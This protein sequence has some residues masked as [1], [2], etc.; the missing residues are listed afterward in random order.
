MHC[1]FFS[2]YR[3][4]VFFHI[5]IIAAY[6]GQDP[7]VYIYFV[8]LCFSDVRRVAAVLSLLQCK[9]STAAHGTIPGFS[10]LPKHFS[11][12]KYPI[13]IDL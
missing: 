7:K 12:H 8:C 1:R 3:S 9:Y 11:L 13:I 2:D 10:A 6:L 5:C 4:Y